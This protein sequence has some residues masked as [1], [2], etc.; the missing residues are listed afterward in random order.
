MGLFSYGSQFLNEQKETKISNKDKP[1]L[2]FI[3]QN[4][5]MDEVLLNPR[6]P[7]NYMTKNGYEDNKT[8]RVCFCPSIGDC[9]TALSMDCKGKTFYVHIADPDGNYD[10]YKPTKDQVPDVNITHELWIKTPVTLKYVGDII[11]T[12][13]NRCGEKYTYGDNKEAELYRWGWKWVKKFNESVF[14]NELSVNGEPIDGDNNDEFS[15]DAEE[16][17]TPEAETTN[18]NNATGDQEDTPENAQTVD[19]PENDNTTENPDDFSIPEDAGSN[20]GEDDTGDPD[21]NNDEETGQNDSEDFSI[22]DPNADDTNETDENSD[23]ASLNTDTDS[24]N[25]IDSQIQQS[26]DQIYETLSD[27]QKKIR[28]LQLKLSFKELYEESDVVLNAINNINKTEDNMDTIRRLINVL[29]NVKQYILDYISKVFDKKTY[30]D[31]N[32]VYVKYINVFRTVR[33]AIDELNK[34]QKS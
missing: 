29:N 32:V 12:A 17:E 24:T 16:A 13:V 21:T 22:G 30:M 15:V 31:N 25:E 33:K 26:E 19:S 23:D 18:A 20:E 14:L 10:V 7:D 11:C 27:D 9:L 8:P 1:T 28:V 6:I 4:E 2:Y 3:S 5:S 34:N